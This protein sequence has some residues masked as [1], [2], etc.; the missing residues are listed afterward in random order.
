MQTITLEEHFSTPDLQRA[1]EEVKPGGTRDQALKAR[2]LDLGQGRLSDMDEGGVDMQV[3]S[4]ASSGFEILESAQATAVARDANDRVADAVR[5]YPQRFAA[6]ANLNLKDPQLAAKEL[7]RCI[8]QLDFRGAIVHGTTGG[9]FMDNACFLPFWESASSLGEP[10]YLHP[11]P[12]PAVVYDTYYAGLPGDCGHPLSINGWGWHTE[13][14]LHVLRLILSGLFDRFPAQQ[15]IIGHMGEDLPYSLA[16]A[17]GVLTPVA[18]HLQRPL[19]EY[20]HNNIHVTTSGYF[21][22]E[23]FECALKIVGIDRLLYSID[24]PFSAVTKGQAF[25]DLLALTPPDRVKF[26]SGNAKRLLKLPF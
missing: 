10:V 3:L 19:H 2:L 9:G 17:T 24:Y 26:A 22:I 15:V 1:I 11:A 16:R 5:K 23:P 6:F 21:T 13:T 4:L 20:F 7:D 8:R 14:G 25:L 12:P 18:K